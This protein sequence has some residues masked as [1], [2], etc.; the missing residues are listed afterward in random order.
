MLTEKASNA[1]KAFLRERNI[2]YIIA[3]KDSLDAKQA[4]EKLKE[5]FG[6]EYIMLGGGGVLNWSFIQ[7]G[8]CDEISVVIAP[9]AD[10][11]V[12]APSLFETKE[13]LSEDR[14]VSFT[15]KNVETKEDSSVWLTYSVNS[16]D[17]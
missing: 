11:A 1:Y 10:G 14:A 17:N 5:L 16:Q 15:L 12:D 7:D 3:G 9:G 6:M 13:G 2:P 8:L 4:M